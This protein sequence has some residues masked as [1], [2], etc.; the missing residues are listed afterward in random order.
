M[1]KVIRGMSQFA[2]AYLDDLIVFS[3]TWEDHLAYLRAVMSRLIE[4]GLMTK[5]SKC[6]AMA[7]CTYL[8]HETR[9]E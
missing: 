4:V 2:S 3:T 8:G 6:L 9:S 7:E 1:D 5:S